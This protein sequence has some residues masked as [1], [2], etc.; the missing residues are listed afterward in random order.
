MQRLDT[1]YVLNLVHHVSAGRNDWRTAVI[2]LVAAALIRLVVAAIIPL[3]PDEAYYWT[4]S[5]N[6]AAGYFDHPPGIALLIR[7]GGDS[8]TP[9]G[10]RLGAVLAG[11]V[12]T[13]ATA[14]TARRIGGDRA[15]LHAALLTACLPMSAGLLLATPDAPLLAAAACGLYAVVRALE[16]LPRSTASLAWWT[17]AGLALGVALG[18]K[19]TA[20]VLAA[21]VGISLA[22]SG[23]LRSRLREPGPWVALAVAALV[24]MPVLLWNAEHG[25][26]SFLFQFRHG[27]A[28]PKQPGLA[29]ALLRQRD[30]LAGM[31]GLASPVLF[32]LF[33]IA[34]A[35]GFSSRASGPQLMLAMVALV[36]TAFFGYGAFRQRVEANWPAPA[37]LPAVVLLATLSWGEPARRWIRAGLA[38][39]A[40]MTLAIYSHALVPILPIAP[41]RDPVGRSAGWD[42]MAAAVDRTRESLPESGATTWAAGDRYQEAALL[43]FH[44]PEHRETFALN[45]AGRPNQYDLW[46]GFAE[47]ASV[48]DNLVLVQDDAP[49][50]NGP[51]T[52][53]FPYFEM[54]HRGELV[55]LRRGGGVVGHRRLWVLAGWKGGWPRRS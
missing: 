35:R 44:D 52:A 27:F 26:I 11:L 31:A 39:A 45:L 54:V 36:T 29:A 46:P 24:F 23:T 32:P 33:A 53:L 20:I 41:S 51:V 42:S 19:Y 22:G 8:P 10:V 3:F 43:A 40:C 38:L 14:A 15:A 16:Q 34:T 50:P 13:L 12:T 5:R 37:Y 49:A 28:L 47:R 17:A 1:A 7:A 6:L 18:S 25:W 48:G 9:L 2:L 21:A 30:Y 4:W 55:T